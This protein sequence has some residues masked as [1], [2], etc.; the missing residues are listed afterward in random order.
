MRY[1]A[2]EIIIFI[3]I[4]IIII[5]IKFS[6]SMY[7]LRL[8]VVRVLDKG[9]TGKLRFT[10][11]TYIDYKS[12]RKNRSEIDKW[13]LL[14]FSLHLPPAKKCF[15]LRTT[16][17]RNRTRTNLYTNFAVSMYNVQFLTLFEN[18]PALDHTKILKLVYADCRIAI[19]L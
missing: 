13:P 6:H 2:I 10:S 8:F 9:A 1:S 17:R 3:V 16:D 18:V 4:I 5:I 12:R 19:S 7:G 15:Q 14:F 11:I